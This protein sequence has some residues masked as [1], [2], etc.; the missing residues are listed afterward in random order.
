M[1]LFCNSVFAVSLKPTDCIRIKKNINLYILTDSRKPEI[2]KDRTGMC[3]PK[4][5]SSQG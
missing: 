3:K 4:K 2:K 5:N 1:E